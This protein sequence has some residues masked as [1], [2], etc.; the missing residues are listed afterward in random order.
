MSE[1][2]RN[3]AQVSVVICSDGRADSLAKLHTALSHQHHTRFEVVYIVGPTEDGAWQAVQRWAQEAPLKYARCPERNLSMARNMGLALAAGDLVAF[4]DDDA[5]PEPEWLT[6]LSSMFADAKVA[7]ASGAVLDYTGVDYQFRFSAADRFGHSHHL[8]AP[9]EDGAYPFS[10]LFPHAMG[11]NCMFRRD[12][13]ARLGGF[14]EEYDYYLDETDLCCRLIDDGWLIAQAS[15][16]PVHHKF[17]PSRLR[18]SSRVLIAKYPVLK[19]K[20]YYALINNRGHA[21]MDEIIAD[22]MAFF[23][24]HRTDLAQHVERE[25][26]P[27]LALQ[28]FD[29]DAERAWRVGLARGLSGERRVHPALKFSEPPPF[30]AFPTRVRATL[31][32]SVALLAGAASAHEPEAHTLGAALAADGYDVHLVLGGSEFEEVDLIDGVWVRRRAARYSALNDSARAVGISEPLWR[33]YANVDDEL[34]RLAEFRH[35][36]AVI[37]LSGQGLSIGAAWRG[38]DNLI[39]R[40]EGES[41][42]AP[43]PTVSDTTMLAIE[44]QLLISAACIITDSPATRDQAKRRLGDGP[45]GQA[46]LMPPGIQTAARFITQILSQPLQQKKPSSATCN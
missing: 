18:D 27:A 35:L 9:F 4:I 3:N 25:R 45:A 19:N 12:V 33:I 20:L 42:V 44:A 31:P 1:P 36:D 26:A 21:R 13:V 7:G 34:Q 8:D 22:A 11:A 29:A 37:D 28:D 46:E 41:L 10:P 6:Q 40:L 39:C 32:R 30:C 5:L 2:H 38:A 16:A 43:A 15:D 23:A 17:L 24:R 14:D